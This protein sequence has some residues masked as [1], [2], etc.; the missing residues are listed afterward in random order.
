MSRCIICNECPEIDYDIPHWSP[1]SEMFWDETRQG[2]VCNSCLTAEHQ[3]LLGY[4]D[5]SE[6]L[7][8]KYVLDPDFDEK[9][10]NMERPELLEE[11]DLGEHSEDTEQ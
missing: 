4:E 6:N 8:D 3:I 5:I 10:D 2:Y 1:K 11:P 9:S 7:Y